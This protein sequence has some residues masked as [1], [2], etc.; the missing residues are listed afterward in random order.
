VL[1]H[2]VLAPLPLLLLHLCLALLLAQSF[3][4]LLAPD[5][6]SSLLLSL[7]GTLPLSTLPLV[8]LLLI[9]LV[10][11]IFVL[12]FILVVFFILVVVLGLLFDCAGEDAVVPLLAAD[13][14]LNLLKGELV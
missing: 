11:V 5:L 8:T 9:V 2:L 10:A 3:V 14:P 13:V 4:L 12:I 7:F 1:R 6:L